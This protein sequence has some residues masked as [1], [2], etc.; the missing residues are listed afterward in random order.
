MDHLAQTDDIFFT[1]TNLEQD[2]AQQIVR[3]ALAGAD[4]G[5]LFLEMRHSEMLAFDDGRLKSASYDQSS[6]FGLRAIA[7]EAMAMPMPVS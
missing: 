6:G 2:K 1:G 5:E 4:D 7:G 3:Q